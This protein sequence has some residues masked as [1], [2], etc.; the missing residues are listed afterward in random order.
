MATITQTPAGTWKAQVRKKGYPPQT[1]T[2]ELRTAAEK[3]ARAI[4]RE[5]DTRQFIPR[6]AAEETTFEMLAKW[7]ER[8]TLSGKKSAVKIRSDLRLLLEAFGRY[9][10]IA[11][12]PA[13]ITSF[14]EERM[15]AGVS[16]ATVRKQIS[17]L[18]RM[19]KAGQV[20]YGIHLPHGNPVALVRLPRDSAARSRRV[21]QEEIEAIISASQSPELPAII[22]L[23]TETAMR[24][25]EIIGLEW[26]HV[27]INSREAHL[28]DT[29]NGSPRDVPLSTRAV[30]ALRSIPRRLSGRV[31]GFSGP[32]GVTRAFSRAVKRARA[33]Y[34]KACNEQGIKPDPRFLVDVRFHDLRHEATSRLFEA[35][36]DLMEAASVT[37][38]KDPRMLKRYTHLKASELAKKLG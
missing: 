27:D 22:R 25:G 5:M 10:L 7:Y 3:W 34:E 21:S 18:G 38:H 23:A 6:A 17:L 13:M 2:F 26:A 4:E 16:G 37:G 20:D 29:K 12:T 30:A 15:S 28:P 14:R 35:G 32:D 24:R 1:R 11:M 8:D 9:A 36:F 19:I 33:N 31:F